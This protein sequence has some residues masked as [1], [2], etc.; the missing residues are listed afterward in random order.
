MI[1][2]KFFKSIILKGLVVFILI[3]I[4]SL[5]VFSQS[6][7]YYTNWNDSSIKKRISEGI[8]TFRK[9]N[10]SIRLQKDNEIINGN[11]KISIQ[12]HSHDFLFGANP[13]YIDGYSESVKNKRWEV[14]F[15]SLFNF[16]TVPLYWKDYEIMPNEYRF[17][18]T[19]VNIFRRPPVDRVIDFCDLYDLK[20][21]GHPLFWDY[22]KWNIPDWFPTSNS[23]EQY[24]HIFNYIDT[25]AKLY[26]TKI[27]Y[28]DVV[29]E[30]TANYEPYN[31]WLPHDHVYEI[32]NYASK[33]IDSTDKFIMN[34][35]LIWEKFRHEYSPF[36]L[37]IQNLVL[38]KA[39]IDG[40]GFQCHFFNPDDFMDIL[41]GK[42][43]T[44]QYVFEVLDAY[45]Y[46]NIP[47][48]ISEITI[49]TL[50]NDSGLDAQA[51]VA[52]N[53]YR[54][55]FSH[56]SI[57]SITWWN[58]ADGTAVEGEDNLIS[59]LIDKDLQPKP[60]FQVLNDLI[61]NEWHTD[62]DWTDAHNEFSFSGFYGKY[63]VKISYKGKLYSSIINLSK[64][65]NII[66][67]IDID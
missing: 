6:I 30:V 11:F 33:V 51:I 21:K 52:R 18:D 13:F 59:G 31:G 47:I 62:I 38:R 53:F 12:Q 10:F 40:L 49:P 5:H 54:L 63:E 15:D 14:L 9:G 67:N 61:N 24:Q 20:P 46:M 45:A 7:D 2:L 50:S 28:W 56:P 48:H 39:K 19:S 37:L 26:D 58:F 64:E 29:N 57:H 66:V 4:N 34:E 23:E 1:D 55:W 41:E 32:I 36:Y 60:S 16:T 3:N 44:P 17:S 25:I 35:T 27:D 43:M 42:K 22:K 8:E 65:S